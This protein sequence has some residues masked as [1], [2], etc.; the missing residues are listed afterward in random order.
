MMSHTKD[1]ISSNQNSQMLWI[2]DPT[3]SGRG[4]SLEK[5]E[6]RLLIHRETNVEQ[7]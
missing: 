3:G 5:E 6:L 7:I 1:H 4:K 2:S